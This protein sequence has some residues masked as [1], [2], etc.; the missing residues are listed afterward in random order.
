MELP[1]W[2]QVNMETEKTVILN[3]IMC[4]AYTLTSNT[5][6][7]GFLQLK[8]II[9]ICLMPHKKFD[10]IGSKFVSDET[11]MCI[12]SPFSVNPN[13]KNICT[14]CKSHLLE[15]ISIFSRA[16]WSNLEFT[17]T[18]WSASNPL[19]DLSPYLSPSNTCFCSISQ[20]FFF[21]AIRRLWNFFL[22][23]HSWNVSKM[24]LSHQQQPV[25][26]YA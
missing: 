25:Q 18:I 13:M 14:S 21:A 11:I 7:M 2:I 23:L 4:A 26:A 1:L 20:S 5:K 6:H 3:S 24:L 12:L 9:F 22:S 17:P 15:D 16:C 10:S 8:V 19:L